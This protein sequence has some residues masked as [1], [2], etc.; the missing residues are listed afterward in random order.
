VIDNEVEAIAGIQF[1]DAI[2]DRQDNLT[3]NEK[4]TFYK[5]IGQAMLIGR[6]QQAW[7]ESS[8]NL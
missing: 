8:V 3:L 6:L 1:D 7:A 2:G 4:A 5:F